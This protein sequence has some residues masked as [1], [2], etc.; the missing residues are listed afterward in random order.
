MATNPNQYEV[1]WHGNAG[2]YQVVYQGRRWAIVAKAGASVNN[3]KAA[4]LA[5]GAVDKTGVNATESI[6]FLE[7]LPIVT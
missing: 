7:T 1:W 6:Y 4:L 2:Q 5:Q 3:Q